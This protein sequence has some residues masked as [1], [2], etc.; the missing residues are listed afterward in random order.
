MQF[1]S[2]HLL[3]KRENEDLGFKLTVF[4][5]QR[6]FAEACSPS[7]ATGRP[8]YQGSSFHDRCSYYSLACLEGKCAHILGA[9]PSS[10]AHILSGIWLEIIHTLHSLWDSTASSSRA[11]KSR[12]TPSSDNSLHLILPSVLRTGRSSGITLYLGDSLY[13]PPISHLDI[14]SSKREREREEEWKAQRV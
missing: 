12:D 10:T 13:I 3:F 9:V 14:L 1:M 2:P 5:Y 8:R 11:A 7:N 6:E 4:D